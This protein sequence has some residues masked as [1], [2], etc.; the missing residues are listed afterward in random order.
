MLRYPVASFNENHP[1]IP[2][3]QII[4]GWVDHAWTRSFMIMKR[5][6]GV[7]M[8]AAIAYTADGQ[9]Q[10][11]GDQVAVQIKTLTQHTSNML[12]TVD[13]FGV[14]ENRLVGWKPLDSAVY[15]P[16]C[17]SQQWPRFTQEEFKAHLKEAS[18]MISIPDSGPNFVLYHS[19]ITTHDLS[20]AAP[21]PVAEGQ[22]VQ[23]IDWEYTSY[24]PRYWVATCA[25]LD[26]P[27]A[28]NRMGT[29]DTR[30]PERLNKALVQAGFESL[31]GSG[32]AAFPMTQT[33]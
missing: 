33:G 16:S 4:Y 29:Q 27:F 28:L 26:G 6:G 25:G 22:R 10:D 8:D 23:I 3:L 19:N 11:V 18:D 14:T 13:R 17:Y 30:W 20:V 9:V 32:G 15:A 1:E 21:R 31:S 7:W 24:W 2:T 5:A 12:E